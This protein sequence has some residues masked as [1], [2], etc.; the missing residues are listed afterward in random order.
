MFKF[1]L[2]KSNLLATNE[3]IHP[4]KERK[5]KF[6]PDSDED[7]KATS[8]GDNDEEKNVVLGMSRAT[9]MTVLGLWRPRSLSERN[10]SELIITQDEVITAFRYV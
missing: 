7:D 6:V 8:E 10:S 1:K 4:S 2:S 9:A 5:S 3:N